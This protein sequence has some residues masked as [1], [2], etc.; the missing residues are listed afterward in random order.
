M[1]NGLKKIS[2]YYFAGLVLLNT[3]FV[4]YMHFFEGLVRRTYAIQIEGE[5]LPPLTQFMIGMSGWTYFFLCLSVLGLGLSLVPKIKDNILI[6]LVFCI[7]I[8]EMLIFSILMFAYFVPL[9][10]RVGPLRG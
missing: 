8:I 3:W 6:H 7:L 9:C 1:K 4:L 10:P 2:T 5:K